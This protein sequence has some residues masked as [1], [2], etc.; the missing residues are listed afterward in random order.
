[1]DRRRTRVRLC[2]RVDG[3]DFLLIAVCK[4]TPAPLHAGRQRAVGNTE[5]VGNHQHLLQL[6][7]LREVAIQIFDDALVKLVNMS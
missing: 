2:F 5:L 7:V 1:M 3:V 6:L 4:I